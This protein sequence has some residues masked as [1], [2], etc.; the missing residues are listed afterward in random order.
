MRREA[1]TRQQVLT[2]TYMAYEGHF[3]QRNVKLLKSCFVKSTDHT[4]SQTTLCG[5]IN[6]ITL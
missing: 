3:A 5:I 2:C 1:E 4:E 6:N